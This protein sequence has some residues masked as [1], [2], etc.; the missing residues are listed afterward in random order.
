MSP[1]FSIVIPTRQRHE[2]LPFA[3]QTVLQQSFSDYEIVVADNCSSHETYDIVQELGSQKIKYFRSDSPLSMSDNWEL[4]VS[5]STGQYVIIFGDDDGLVDGS[6][7]YLYKIIKETGFELIRWERVYYSWPNI[8]P[9]EFSNYL[10]VPLD[11][12]SNFKCSGKETIQAV[13]DLKLDYTKLPMLYNSVVK[14]D[15]LVILKQETGRIFRSITPD[16]YSGYALAYLVKNY[17][18]ISTPLSINGGSAKS[19]GTAHSF[20]SDNHPIISDFKQLN[21]RSKLSFH[22]KIPDIRSMTSCI[23]E[24]F[25]QLQDAFEIQ[26]IKI[27]KTNIFYSILRDARFFSFEEK[28]QVLNLLEHFCRQDGNLIS[29]LQSEQWENLKLSSLTAFEDLGY[30]KGLNDKTY[31]FDASDFGVSNVLDVSKFVSKF[32]EFDIEKFTYTDF[33]FESP[34]FHNSSQIDTVSYQLELANLQIEAM[35]SSKFWKFREVWCKLKQILNTNLNLSRNKKETKDSDYCEVNTPL[36]RDRYINS[37]SPI[38]NELQTFFNTKD[39]LVIFDIGSCEG[40]DS[41]KYSRIF[42]FSKIYAVEALPSNLPLL[43]G[44]LDKYAVFN[45]EILPFALSN[46]KGISKFYVSSGKPDEQPDNLDWDFGNKSSSLL[47]PDK[48]LETA[49]WLKFQS[50]IDVETR[51]IKDICTEKRIDYIDFIHMD[52]Q[53]AELKVLEG[54]EDILEKVKVIWLEVESIT[55]YENQPLKPDIEEFMQQHSFYKVKDTVNS[56]SGD[57]LYINTKLISDYQY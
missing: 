44:N 55:L 26:D 57:Q 46:N 30:R 49:P 39:A 4:A 56:I 35:Q 53:G 20:N 36:T 19:N 54:A 43:K 21:S 12:N 38:E 22:P 13:I 31:T 27:D 8:E 23:V 32:Y 37:P 34:S 14:K 28:N 17:L 16:I 50:V 7:F 6:L 10:A 25:F 15:W 2:T 11:S 5:M 47:P 1:F 52:V 18:S 51:T 42:P 41:I 45:V 24:P 33:S 3:I 40:E 9:N 29:L 48:H